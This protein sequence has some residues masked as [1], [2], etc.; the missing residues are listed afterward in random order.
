MHAKPQPDFNRLL[1]VLRRTGEPDRVP[2]I[3]LSV[4]MSAI[5]RFTGGRFEGPMTSDEYARK[6]NGFWADAGYD[7]SRAIPFF[8]LPTDM[9]QG[10]ASTKSSKRQPSGA[11][12]PA[13]LAGTD[14]DSGARRQWYREH[15]GL[16]RSWEDFY[17]YPWPEPHEVDY[18]FVE[19]VNRNLPDGMKNVP[20]T[21]GIFEQATFLMGLVDFSYAL[22]DEPDLVEAIINKLGELDLAVYKTMADMEEVGAIWLTDDLGFNTG[23]LVAP[24]VLRKHVFPWHK[25]IARAAHD[26]GKPLLIH[27]CGNV[28]EVMPDLIDDVGID[29]KHSFQANIYDMAEQKRK[30]GTR[31]ALLGG[32][33]VDL[34]ARGT[35]DEV[36]REV[37]RQIDACA[38][39]GAYALSSSNSIPNYAKYENYAAMID[40]TLNYGWYAR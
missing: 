32:V 11:V 2:L 27:S 31:I 28:E 18:G 4:D 36:R 21:S 17:N 15:G 25:K 39:G 13:D 10:M 8:W 12:V 40:E 38:P 26:K 37:R 6:W 16:I 35:E 9:T 24:E 22:V 34:L 7:C 5:I 20:N 3:E 14:P 33:D 19:A 29:A 30:Y 23:T 1:K